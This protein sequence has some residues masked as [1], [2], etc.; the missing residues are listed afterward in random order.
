MYWRLTLDQPQSLCYEPGYTRSI[1]AADFSPALDLSDSIYRDPTTGICMLQPTTLDRSY[2]N[3]M[4]PLSGF[5]VNGSYW[6]QI[7]RSADAALFLTTIKAAGA[8]PTLIDILIT[9][10]TMAIEFDAS[11]KD[12]LKWAMQSKWLLAAD[13]AFALHHNGIAD[14]ML[15]KHNWFAVQW[16]NIGLH[17]SLD[18]QVRVYTYDRTNMTAAPV[19]FEQFEVASPG[20]LASKDGFF[21]FIPIPSVGLMVLH[22]YQQQGINT[23]LS[24]VQHQAS[25]GH[26]IR[27]PST[28]APNGGYTMFNASKVAIALNPYQDYAIGFQRI[29]F[30]SSGTMVDGNFGMG[31]YPS[32]AP[33]TNPNL[34]GV[35]VLQTVPLK[36]SAVSASLTVTKQDG[37]TAW[38]PA[39]TAEG[40]QARAAIALSTSDSKYTP[41]VYGYNITW[42]ASR[43]TRDTT[44]VVINSVSPGVGQHDRL[45]R[46]EW[47][48]D[49]GGH[50]EGSA[51]MTLETPAAQWIGKRGDATFKL[52]ASPDN[53]AWSTVFAGFAKEW[54]LELV[55]PIGP[56]YLIA[57]CKLLSLH[58]RL[59]EVHK[60]F[61]GSFDGMT[62]GDAI[63]SV[64]NVAGYARI[65]M[66]TAANVQLPKPVNSQGWKLTPREGDSGLDIIRMM[67]TYLKTQHVQWTLPYDY[68]LDRFVLHQRPYWNSQVWQLF[69][70]TSSKNANQHK[71]SYGSIKDKPEP[72]EANVVIAEGV[73]EP[74]EPN[75]QQMQRFRSDAIVN[76]NSFDNVDSLDYLGRHVAL[77]AT[78]Y[79][80]SDQGA[81]N[82]MARRLYD[83]VAIHRSTPTIHL[84]TAQ[85]AIVPD[86]P[87][88]VY[89]ES[90]TQIY[91]AIVKRRSVIIEQMVPGWPGLMAEEMDIDIDTIWEEAQL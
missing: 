9:I 69:M 16:D 73:F 43:E 50:I 85:F 72:P 63:N 62:V 19:Q 45:T 37:T 65:P 60:A 30:P 71:W 88:R 39:T 58:E 42:D 44:P 12:N 5:T 55:K 91:Y 2:Y 86:T 34:T 52:E 82:I 47:S 28:Q 57:T 51:T 67:L 89:D 75:N 6:S 22:S 17:F 78:F 13:E 79:P 74:P 27:W 70:T 11:L 25:R 1:Q 14:N 68:D 48:D 8:D 53:V 84:P 81:V 56:S 77:L 23:L 29:R 3:D 41:F 54:E 35:A 80:L 90:G 10:A 64:L 49:V 31:Y 21:W 18:G 15:R 40:K 20:D 7:K 4:Q 26:L 83:V 32:A 38:T 46:M 36:A 87:V 24:N 66:P 59:R 76:Y 33:N 61:E